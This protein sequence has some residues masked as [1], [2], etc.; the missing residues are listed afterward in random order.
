MISFRGLLRRISS[1]GIPIYLNSEVLEISHGALVIR[2]EQEI[3]PLPADTVVLAVGVKPEDRL[4]G[5]L[6]GLVPEIYPIGDCVMPGNAAQATY[7]AL[8]LALK[9]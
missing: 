1:L 2:F 4:V 7:S 8:R 6:K 9:L 5:E 3:L